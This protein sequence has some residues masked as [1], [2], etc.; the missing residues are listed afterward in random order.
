MPDKKMYEFIVE[1][2]GIDFSVYLVSAVNPGNAL[3]K[4]CKYTEE[5]KGAHMEAICS[6]CFESA[7]QL[8][9]EWLEYKI[10]NIHEV[11]EEIFSLSDCRIKTIKQD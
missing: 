11:G 1:G 9:N 10:I 4:Y 8:A 6:L 3:I 2:S 5:I 7:I